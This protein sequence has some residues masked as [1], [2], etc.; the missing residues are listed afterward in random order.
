M[1]C[2]NLTHG[3][4]CYQEFRASSADQQR[5][6]CFAFIKDNGHL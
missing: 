4:S 3:S 5:A 2:L 6:A 1:P